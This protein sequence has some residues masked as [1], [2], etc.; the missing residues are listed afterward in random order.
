[1][2]LVAWNNIKKHDCVVE[3]CVINILRSIVVWPKPQIGR[4]W[5]IV[6]LTAHASQNSI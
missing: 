4:Y 5:C 1:L 6:E 3:D 2:Y